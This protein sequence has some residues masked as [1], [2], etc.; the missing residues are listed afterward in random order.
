MSWSIVQLSVSCHVSLVIGINDTYTLLCVAS[1]ASSS[2]SSV[3][4]TKKSEKPS[5]NSY[6][7]KS[8]INSGFWNRQ[9]SCPPAL[10]LLE[11][12]NW[13][14]RFCVGRCC[15]VLMLIP[16]RRQEGDLLS[17][18]LV[19]KLINYYP[20]IILHSLKCVSAVACVEWWVVAVGMHII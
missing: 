12:N 18:D 17:R 3:H 14:F 7:N 11:V 15:F 1:V 16:E 8:T 19:Y 13:L 6:L 20:Y 9:T 5:G 4:H 10:L 2:S